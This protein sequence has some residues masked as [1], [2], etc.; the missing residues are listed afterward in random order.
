MVKSMIYRLNQ[1]LLVLFLL[2]GFQ[3]FSQ[4][5]CTDPN[6]L[7]FNSSATIN[8]GSCLYAPATLA[9][10]VVGTI[11][12]QA[13]ESSGLV[14]FNEKL[15]THNDSDNSPKLFGFDT[16]N[17]Q[18]QDTLVIG[19]Q[20][21]IDWEDVAVS[22]DFVF[23]G[24]FGNNSA[25]RTDL[26]IL[27]INLSDTQV[28]DTLNAEE[29][30]FYY[31]DQTNFEPSGNHGF[32]CEAFFYFNDSLH[33]FT[34]HWGNG[35][36]KHYIVPNELG[37]HAAVF[38]DS[39]FVNGQVTAADISSSGIIALLGY[40]PPA[41]APFMQLLWDY[42]G[43]NFF[44]GNKRRLDMGNVLTMGQQEGLV[45]SSPNEGYISSERISTP[46]VIASRFFSFDLDPIFNPI[47]GLNESDDVNFSLFPNPFS[48]YFTIDIKGNYTISVE[49]MHGK[50]YF[51]KEYEGKQKIYFNDL[52]DG[53]YF[54]KIQQ[55]ETLHIVKL[56]KL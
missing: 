25:T 9:C 50:N 14:L 53:T 34:K 15:W 51:Q 16:T 44:T 38:V 27:R 26:R 56:L 32:D 41:Y 52:G 49:D 13:Y 45:F 36:T 19:N 1:S 42:Q 35:Y 47:S 20:L 39:L 28:L 33:L 2:T 11:P 46:I 40:T 18:I 12:S 4:S 5:G 30:S 37:N 48:E 22:D 3:A 23:I 21:N 10:P 54:L 6:A 43:T 31:P 55:N 29:I 7:N 24:D 8:D 17:F